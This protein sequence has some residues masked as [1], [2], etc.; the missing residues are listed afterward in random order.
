MSVPNKEILE[1]NFKTHSDEFAQVGLPS[2]AN[3]LMSLEVTH[4]FAESADGGKTLLWKEIFFH[5]NKAHRGL[6]SHHYREANGL[7]SGRK[8]T[9][10]VKALGLDGF[11][12]AYLG[13]HEPY[14]GGNDVDPSFGVFISKDLERLDA[15]NASRRDFASPEIK[16]PFEGEF[17]TPQDARK[18]IAYEVQER[19]G[20]DV[21]YY[22]GAPQHWKDPVYLKE[23]WTR[24]AEMHFLRKVSAEKI[25]AIIWP[26]KKYHIQGGGVDSS[27]Q[28]AER[29]SFARQYPK[30][31]IYTYEW[32]ARYGQDAFLNASY[33]V[34]K[35]FF[36]HNEYPESCSINL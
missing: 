21:W 4:T 36:D 3:Q 11:V 31:K 32:T 33:Y 24:K 19:Y 7:P 20:G 29:Q 27:Y 35:Y 26:D 2:F 17:L 15:A 16:K 30:I 22:W 34:S 18:L 1:R 12:F 23:M 13:S 8:P 25:T 6:L 10:D 14:Y 5:A 9:G 28:I